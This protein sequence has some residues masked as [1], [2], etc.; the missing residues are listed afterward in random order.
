MEQKILKSNI[1]ANEILY[2]EW[3]EQPV[4]VEFTLPDFCPDISK[5]LKCR[6]IARISS[7]SAVNKNINID[8]S[9][10]ITVLYADKN[11][12]LCSY[13]Y[14]YPFNK[15]L[16]SANDLNG[17]SIVCN[18]SC[19]YINCRA[20]TGRKID[21]HGAIGINIKAFKRK[22]TEIIS[23]IESP[24]IELK[25]ITAPATIPMGYV[26]KYLILEEDL[27]IGQG[28]SQ[29][30]RLIRYDANTCVKES[31]IIDD[32]I[33]IK[34]EMCLSI[35]YCATGCDLPQ[36]VKTVIP[37]SQI[38]E[39]QGITELC[40][41][42]TKSTIAFLE[43]K[44]KNSVLGE[45][46]CFSITAKILLGCEVYCG[47]DIAVISDAFS[48]KYKAEILKEDICFEKITDNIKEIFHYK[49]N[50]EIGEDISSIL[51]IWAD[52]QASN[53]SFQDGYLNLKGNI[54][55][56]IAAVDENS[57]I[58]YFEKNVE[59]EH[60]IEIKAKNEILYCNPE[61]EIAALN[62]TILTPNTIEL[63]I[64][65]RINASVYGCEKMKLVTGLQVDE[66]CMLEKKSK[67]AMTIYFTNTQEDIWDIARNYNSSV[68]EIMS[69]NGLEEDILPEGKMILIPTM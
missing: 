54:I 69:I 23:E 50:L 10:C 19:E 20:V 55:V 34:G 26:E 68:A 60:R 40:E 49:N 29:I 62:F 15:N 48:R 43:V 66:K 17:A 63:R 53:A 5:I 14:Q 51:D 65:I 67:G 12:K 36:N 8:G 41:C 64:D 56:G 30:E 22:N 57:A 32:K 21:I 1:F 11:N 58:C 27:N 16:E 33:L 37:F 18:C 2:N 3:C 42:E 13:E 31:K 52:V 4:D 45:T 35:L 38:I 25:R 44:P 39:L 9:V 24:N 46:K 47:N 7:K 61:I 28:Q 6:A 59:F